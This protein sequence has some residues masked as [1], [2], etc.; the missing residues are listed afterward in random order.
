M[1]VY[2]RRGRW[3]CDVTIDGRRAQ[4][5]LKK[6]RTRAQAIKATAVIEN[7][8]F[9]NRY[10]IEKRPEFALT[11]SSRIISCLT[12]SYTSGRTPMT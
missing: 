7:K 4:R 6:A 5:V 11:N 8:L 3:F 10:K 12:Q 9:E 2:K 1:S